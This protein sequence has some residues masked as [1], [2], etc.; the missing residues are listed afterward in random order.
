MQSADAGSQ[1]LH[2]GC[3]SAVGPPCDQPLSSSFEYEVTADD[4]GAY[5]LT[6]NHTTWHPNQNLSVSVNGGAAQDVPVYY[7]VGWW[8]QTEPVELALTKGKNMLSFTRTSTRELVFKDFVLYKKKPDI[9]PPPGNYTPTPAPVFPNKNAYIEVPADTTCV[10]QGITPVPAADCSR[11][12]GALGF[13]ST[14]PR[15]RANISGCF[16]MTEGPY[17][18][19]CNFN[20]NKSATCEPPCTLMGSE[21][22]SLCLR[23]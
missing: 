10:K 1:I 13:K 11:A 7:T 14:G 5:Y 22:R 15:A 4:A 20:S 16:V 6:A 18:G 8:N 19:N 12:C 23:K 9:R 2:G 21:V 3:S 17:K